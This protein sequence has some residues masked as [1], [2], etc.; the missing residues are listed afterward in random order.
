MQVYYVL[1]FAIAVAVI[2]AVYGAYNYMFNIA[3]NFFADELENAISMLIGVG[4]GE[5]R[6][7]VV[8][9]PGGVEVEVCNYDGGGYCGGKYKHCGVGGNKVTR[10]AE[11][12]QLSIEV[13]INASEHKTSAMVTVR[14]LADQDLSFMLGAGLMNRLA[15]PDFSDRCKDI[16]DRRCLYL[17]DI[18]NFGSN[19]PHYDDSLKGGESKSYEFVFKPPR[20]DV[21]FLT[22]VWINIGGELK[23]IAWA[24]VELTPPACI[25]I[26]RPDRTTFIP[27]PYSITQQHRL[28][29]GQ[30]VIE[31]KTQCDYKQCKVV[32]IIQK[33]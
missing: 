2:A 10:R 11:W 21:V 8:T 24:A 31:T 19:M 12:P 32:L 29:P 28:T 26:T 3:T 7:A 14:N 1:W 33:I 18:I 5:E 9:V 20:R 25:V 23:M 27:A 16:H 17:G 22:A 15:Y 13:Q 30:Y 4:V 6:K